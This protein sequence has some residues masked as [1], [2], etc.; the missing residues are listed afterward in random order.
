[1][2]LFHYL[3]RLIT[4]HYIGDF[5]VQNEFQAR[6]KNRQKMPISFAGK[7]SFQWWW[8]FMLAHSGMH[9]LFVYI[10]TGSLILGFSEI[11]VH[12]LLDWGKCEGL[13]GAWTDQTGHIISKLLWSFY[14]F[15]YI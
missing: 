5:I 8:Q 10:A 11:M 4:F 1:M 7:Q 2:M 12:F 14:A 3:F 15:Y 6:A 9:G 13:Y